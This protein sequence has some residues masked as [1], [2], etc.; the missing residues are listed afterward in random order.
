V[1][2]AAGICGVAAEE[3]VKMQTEYISRVFNLDLPKI[4]E[5]ATAELTVFVPA[6]EFVF[7]EDQIYSKSKNN[8]FISKTLKG[9]VFG[10]IN[11]D[12]L[13]LNK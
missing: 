6:E 13:F 10:I 5:G 7:E 12:K 4:E 11:K 1:F 2:G 9:K 3:F 8:A